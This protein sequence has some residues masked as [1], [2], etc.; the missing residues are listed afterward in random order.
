MVATDRFQDVITNEEELRAVVG[1]PKQMVR[2]K[3]IPILDEHCR[4]FIAHS[5]F[6]VVSSSDSAGRQD[7]SPKG[8]EPGFVLVLD[9]HTLVIP[10]RTGN[11]RADTFVNVL[12]NPAVGLLFLVPGSGETLRVNG[13]AQIV[14]DKEL[15]E[16]MPAR[17][18]APEL[19]LVVTVEEAFYHCA[20]C[21]IRS[22]LWNT[23][24]WPD[25]SDLPTYAETIKAQ[26]HPKE[27]V[28]EI[29]RILDHAYTNE[30]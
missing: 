3:V 1:T 29:Q 21:I 24:E 14:K 12:E 30:L 4:R 9:E 25:I 8:D 13:H 20:K 19:A 18:K 6:L 28:E 15:L 16:R 23:D 2:D 22:D 7:V 10:D 5:P 27:S 11:R 26:R 17:G